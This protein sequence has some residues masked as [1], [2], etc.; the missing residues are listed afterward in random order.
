MNLTID[1]SVFVASARDAEP[2]FV[3]SRRFLRRVNRRQQVYSVLCWFCRNVHLQSRARLVTQL[4]LRSL[5]D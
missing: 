1:A 5:S 3:S 2:N 4:W